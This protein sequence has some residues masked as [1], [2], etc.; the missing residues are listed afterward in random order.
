MLA[1]SGKLNIYSASLHIANISSALAIRG[2]SGTM[3]FSAMDSDNS[4]SSSSLT[5]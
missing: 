2:E 3:K 4:G 5:P 1:S